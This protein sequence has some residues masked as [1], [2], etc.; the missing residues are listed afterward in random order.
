MNR[1]LYKHRLF[2]FL[3]SEESPSPKSLT[4][5]L[6]SLACLRE[7]SMLNGCIATLVLSVASNIHFLDRT[8]CTAAPGDVWAT[9]R[10][11]GSDRTFVKRLQR[12]LFLL[13]IQ[14]PSSLVWLHMDHGK[15]QKQQ[16]NNFESLHGV[17][18]DQKEANTYLKYLYIY[19]TRGCW[20]LYW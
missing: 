12:K 18:K 2:D 19:L 3:Q 15:K 9:G 17:N 13:H 16:Q 8:V 11:W 5:K 20:H 10:P 6:K 14:Y 7:L 4:W 1:L